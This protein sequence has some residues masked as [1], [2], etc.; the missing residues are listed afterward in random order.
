MNLAS[1]LEP[2]PADAPALTSSGETTTYGA[3]RQQVAAVSGGLT[4]AGLR[5]GDR[6]ALV[7]ASNWYFVVAQ[8]AVLRCGAVVVPL[9][10]QSPA[11][12]LQREL[13]SVQPRVAIVGP[14]GRAAFADVDR[15]AAGIELVFVPEGVALDDARSFEDLLVADAEPMVERSP[16]DLAALMFTSGTAGSPRA[17][18]LTHGNLLSNL[19]QMQAAGENALRPGD[20]NFCV[21]PLS[22]IYGLNASLNLSL[23]AGARIVLVQRFDPASALQSIRDHGVTV[24]AGVPPMYGAWASLPEESAPPDSFITVRLAASGASRLDPALAQQFRDRFGVGIGEGYGLTE[25]SPAVTGA[26]FPTPRFGTIGAPLPGVAVRVVDEDGDDVVEGD[27]GE[28]WVRGANVFTGYWH[29]PEATARAL[30]PDGWLRTGDIAVV[31][32]HGD[33]TIVDRAKDLIIVSGFNVFPGEVEEVLRTHPGIEDAAVIGM[34]HPHTG[35][36]VKAL[37]VPA[38]G[39]LLDED[40]VIEFCS[41]QLARYKCPSKVLVVNHLPRGSAGKLLR[42]D[43]T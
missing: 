15:T 7:L 8:F 4:D 23:Y 32:E 10:P 1:I 27:P 26:S 34:P 41:Q 35:E 5:P 14:A 33:L 21:I 43:L 17:A 18:Q 24:V 30:T 37:V 16:H 2:H 11:A 29:D 6:V 19:E 40:E 9:N 3:L 25:A 42:R 38:P 13:D 31:D 36:S 22:H 39:R 12:E 28:I 20:V